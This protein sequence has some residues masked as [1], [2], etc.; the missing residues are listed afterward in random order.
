MSPA[1]KSILKRQNGKTKMEIGNE[2]D[3]FLFSCS[4]DALNVSLAIHCIEC[5]YP[6]RKQ[7]KNCLAP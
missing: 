2:I 3:T 5:S 1:L 7:Q 4:L 6:F